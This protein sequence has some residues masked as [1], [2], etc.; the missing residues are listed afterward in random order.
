MGSYGVVVSA[1]DT[2]TNTKVAI[3][4]ILQPMKYTPILKR[5]LREIKLL[6]FMNQE[7]IISILDLFPYID[8]KSIES[9]Y[10][11][12]ELMSSDLMQVIHSPAPLSEQ[13]IKYVLF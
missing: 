7:N 13:H 11:V 10:M 9:V 8:I 5:T 1:L 3:K 4:K 2:L 6:N 12:T